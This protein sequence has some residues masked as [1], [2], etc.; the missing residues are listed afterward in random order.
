[1]SHAST[2]FG[3]R[4]GKT[5]AFICTSHEKGLTVIDQ[6]RTAIRQ[7]YGWS[8]PYGISVNPEQDFDKDHKM[9]DHRLSRRLN[10]LARD[11][12]IYG[13]MIRSQFLADIQ[14]GM[15]DTFAARYR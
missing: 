1:M 5:F 12:T 10:M 15:K 7:C 8:L 6:M 11:L 14:D 2:Y 4:A 9:A 13:T 3:H